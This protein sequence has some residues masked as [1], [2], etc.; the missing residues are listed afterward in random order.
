MFL[1][2]KLQTLSLEP[3]EHLAYIS[4]IFNDFSKGG[5]IPL[6]LL[7]L[8]VFLHSVYAGRVCRRVKLADIAAAV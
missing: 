7:P 1:G 3:T 6:S 4:G 8:M 2:K 5:L